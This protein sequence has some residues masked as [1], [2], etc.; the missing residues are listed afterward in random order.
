M[1]RKQIIMLAL[2]AVFE[3][4]IHTFVT[5]I[6]IGIIGRLGAYAISTVGINGQI[7]INAAV[8]LST[9]GVGASVLIARAVGKK[10]AAEGNYYF[11]KGLGMGIFLALVWGFSF[12]F[13]VPGIVNLITMD[14][15]LRTILTEYMSIVA[16]PSGALLLLFILE[17]MVRGAGHTIVT[18]LVAA[19]SS[20][21][22]VIFSYILINGKFGFS[23]LG[24]YGAAW[25]ASIAYFV[26][27][28]V[29]F[30][31]IG[32]KRLKVRIVWREVFRIDFSAYRRI[33][34]TGLPAAVD[35]G[36]WAMNQWVLLGILPGLGAVQFAAHQIA[37]STEGISFMPGNGF[38]IAAQILVGQKLGAG[39]PEE[40]KQ[41][42]KEALKIA[43]PIMLVFS[44]VFFFFSTR[45]VGVFTDKQ[46][47]IPLAATCLSIGAFEQPAIAVFMVL[48]GAFRGAGDTKWPLRLSII[49]YWIIRVPLV[50]L[51]IKVMH[52][53]ITAF[54]Y[55]AVFQWTIA[56]F[57][58]WLRFRSGKWLTVEV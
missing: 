19:F 14:D 17:S 9:I 37:M 25:G 39:L 3:M 49:S 28:L 38:A 31:I 35:E 44:T 42:T 27:L 5:V 36:L 45:L 51:A 26:A 52:F 15:T 21:T 6:I 12:R 2:P 10:D 54:W 11:S 40:A 34:N 29:M 43:V 1:I 50:W 22:N 46:E 33:L 23:A 53:D 4:M 20:T 41:A 47:L 7:I 32:T 24:L 48:V 57:L 58:C 8:I 16:V 13:A 56:A 18:L 30:A 55:V